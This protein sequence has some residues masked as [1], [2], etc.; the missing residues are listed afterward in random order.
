MVTEDFHR[1]RPP[2]SDYGRGLLRCL[3]SSPI[4]LHHVDEV[5]SRA[6][7]AQSH[8]GV[9]NLVLGQDALHRV[10]VQLALCAL[11]GDGE[12]GAGVTTQLKSVNQ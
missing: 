7:A 2:W 10:A 11:V 8:V 1:P 6:V 12:S 4:S 5:V 3:G 9:V